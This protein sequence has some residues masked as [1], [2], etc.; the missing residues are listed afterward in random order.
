MTDDTTSPS[1]PTAESESVEQ[2]EPPHVES[3]MTAAD[4][5]REIQYAGV[6]SQAG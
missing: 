6:A 4:L 2:Y 5:A 3:V 1:I